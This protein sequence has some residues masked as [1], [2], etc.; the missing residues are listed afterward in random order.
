MVSG[1]SA[2]NFSCNRMPMS[3]A[4]C[5]SNSLAMVLVAF[6][7]LVA[8]PGRNH[9]FHLAWLLDHGLATQ[10]GVE[11]QIGCHVEPVGFVVVHLAEQLFALS[12]M[13]VA[14]GAGVVA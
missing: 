10:A 13:H 6:L 4:S 1:S 7:N 12:Y 9:D 14:R 11:L 2:G 8:V 3:S 5:Q